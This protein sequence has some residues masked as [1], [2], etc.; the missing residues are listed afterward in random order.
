MNE[1]GYIEQRV[2]NQIIWY[3]EKSQ[4]NQRWFKRLQV[5]VILASATIPFLVGIL[6]SESIWLKVIVG[7]LGLIVAAA[8]SILGLYKFQ[9][10]WIEYRTTCESL[11][12]EKF[13]FLT[14]TDPYNTEDPFHL[15][16]ERVEGLISKE[17]TDWSKYQKTETPGESVSED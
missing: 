5:S 9:E 1:V 7:S 6:P 17:N 15:F 14:K 2:E 13:L 16:V 11:R 3:D 8:A 12:H 4:F 10:N